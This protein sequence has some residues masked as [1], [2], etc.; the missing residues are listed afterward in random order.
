MWPRRSFTLHGGQRVARSKSSSL[1]SSTIAETRSHS[2]RR[3]LASSEELLAF[4]LLHR[5]G[6]VPRGDRGVRKHAERLLQLV[7]RDHEREEMTKHVVVDAA[8]DGHDAALLCLLHEGGEVL[9][10]RLLGVA[11]AAHL[12]ADHRAD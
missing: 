9:P 4:V 5:S 8:G 3:M 7:V 2:P 10:V 12:H 1:R 6:L 11:V